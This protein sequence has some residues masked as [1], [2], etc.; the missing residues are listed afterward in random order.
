MG[1]RWVP[2][3]VF[4]GCCSLISADSSAIEDEAQAERYAEEYN[5]MAEVANNENA[6]ATWAYN[7]D[8]TPENQEAQVSSISLAGQIFYTAI[9]LSCMR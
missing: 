5:V 7:T 9:L 6:L 2:V 8:L 4:A 1:L 3:I